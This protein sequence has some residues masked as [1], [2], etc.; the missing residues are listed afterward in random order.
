MQ[1]GKKTEGLPATAAKAFIK[2]YLSV[3]LLYG[4]LYMLR[5]LKWIK[6]EHTGNPGQ[7]VIANGPV[8]SRKNGRF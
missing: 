6:T 5:Q 4:N 2:E 3:S 8:L 1:G 7:K